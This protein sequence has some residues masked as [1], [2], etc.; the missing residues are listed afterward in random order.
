MCKAARLRAHPAAASKAARN[1][2]RRRS[3]RKRVNSQSISRIRISERHKADS[4]VLSTD[5]LTGKIRRSKEFATLVKGP[6]AVRSVRFAAL[7][8]GLLASIEGWRS[9]VAR[10]QHRYVGLPIGK[11]YDCV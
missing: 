7:S 5:A 1:E 6:K 2:I 9:R 11:A 3:K 10:Y 4:G 8:D